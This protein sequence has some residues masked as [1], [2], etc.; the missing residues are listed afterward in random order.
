MLVFYMTFILTVD[1]IMSFFKNKKISS[2]RGGSFEM[3]AT[4][5]STPVSD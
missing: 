5:V 4:D 1:P 3:N 2:N